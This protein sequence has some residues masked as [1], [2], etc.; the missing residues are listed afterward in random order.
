M[1]EGFYSDG[2]NARE[3]R[4]GRGAHYSGRGVY[5]TSCTDLFLWGILIDWIDITPW[6]WN[7]G[8]AGL[9]SRGG[10]GLGA[11]GSGQGD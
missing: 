7:P 8:P 11:L 4:N 9:S 1:G 2:D 6:F 3:Y 10:W 5:A